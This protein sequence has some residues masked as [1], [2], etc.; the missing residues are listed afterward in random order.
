VLIIY[1]INYTYCSNCLS[2]PRITTKQLAALLLLEQEKPEMFSLFSR[3]GIENC[4]CRDG[5]NDPHPLFYI[6]KIGLGDGSCPTAWANVTLEIS[7]TYKTKNSQITGDVSGVKEITMKT[8]REVLLAV[9]DAI[10]L[11]PEEAGPI[12]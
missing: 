3:I 1:I 2:I 7:E 10:G 6:K 5:G 8:P 9:F 11:F 4:V 12:A